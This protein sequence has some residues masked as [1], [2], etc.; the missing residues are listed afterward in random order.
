MNILVLAENINYNRTSSGIRSFNFL[1]LLR[2]EHDVT[3]ICLEKYDDS[4][5]IKLN[6][7]EISVLEQKSELGFCLELFDKIPKFSGL[8]THITGL[9]LFNYRLIKS[10]LSQINKELTKNEFD[11]IFVLG[12]G[13]D[14]VVHH[15]IARLTTN[16]PIIAHIHDPY[17][18]NQYPDPYR[19]DKAVY[20]PLAKQFGKVIRRA[21]FISFPSLLLKNWMSKF[22]P[23]IENKHLIFPHP[24]S[25]INSAD[26]SVEL[27]SELELKNKFSLIHLGSLLDKRNPIHLLRAYKRFCDSSEEKRLNSCLYIIGRMDKSHL[28]MITNDWNNFNNIKAFN[29]RITYLQSKKIMKEASV[30][31]LLE[32]IASFSPFMP[33]KL[34]DYIVAN[35]PILAL[36]PKESEVSRLLGKDYNYSCEVDDED[37]ILKRIDGLWEEW[38]R[39]NDLSVDY[40]DLNKYISVKETLARFEQALN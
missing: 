23:E 38:K 13:H 3:C 31:I 4:A 29:T 17:P 21:N 19:K 1:N 24:E 8:V 35:K 26:Y 11:L 10:W 22:Y 5:E 9:N 2:L 27:P 20:K 40:K 28:K 32:A 14:F 33:G 18:F 16:I 36:T 15:A 30:L 25:L 37:M 34:S 6:D 12:T 7:V 39:D